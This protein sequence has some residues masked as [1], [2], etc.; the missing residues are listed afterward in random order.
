MNVARTTN[1]ISMIVIA[2]IGVILIVI[3]S[4]INNLEGVK[5]E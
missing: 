4:R 1:I 3:V 2:N 5:N